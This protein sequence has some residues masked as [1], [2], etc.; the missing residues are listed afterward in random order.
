MRNAAAEGSDGRDAR[1]AGDR[2]DAG[3]LL[4]RR[5]VLTRG[6]AGAGALAF[7]GVLSACGAGSKGGT[8]P[9]GNTGPSVG[10]GKEVSLVTFAVEN[11][12]ASMDYAQCYDF[13]GML[14]VPSITE[15]LLR[16]DRAGRLAP[17][18]AT[19]Y[20][21]PDPHRVVFTIRPGVR[22]HDGTP[23]TA[24]D[25]AFSMSRH[26]DPNVASLLGF[27]YV[28]VDHV[29]VTGPLEVTAFMKQPDSQFIAVMSTNA[30]A[31]GSKAFIEKHGKQYGS[32]EIGGL[33]TGPY[34]FVSWVKGQS[35]TVERNPDYWNGKVV[36]RKVTRFTARVIQDEAT[37]LTALRAG[38]IDGQLAQLSGR[39][40]QSLSTA[41]N[42][43]QYRV[44][45]SGGSYLSFNLARKPWDDSRVRRALSLVV[46]RQGLLDSVWGG[47][48]SLI[49]SMVAPSNW[50]YAKSTFAAAYAQLPDYTH[51]GPVGANLADA[52]KLISQAGAHGTKGS[53]WVATQYDAQQAQSI[54]AAASQI[55][56][57]LSVNTVTQA[58]MSAGEAAKPHPYDLLISLSIPDVPDPGNFL[59]LLYAST[60]TSNVQ[61]YRNPQ[62]DAWLAEQNRI[63][64][65]PTKRAELLT[66]VQEV[67]VRDQVQAVLVGTDIVLSMNSRLGGYQLASPQFQWDCQLIGSISGS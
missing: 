59:G 1:N 10:G 41:T 65:D 45:S 43:R 38:E 9:V 12:A 15:P 3:I 51:T 67:I 37:L 18:V 54:Q 16:I 13:S 26:L 39:G 63:T 22:F 27:Y 33:G 7:T 58:A 50:S 31:V 48:G 44:P 19:E 29:A 57:D 46:P 36:P 5:E 32:P 53:I 4:R 35:Y 2:E 30:G 52:R 47:Q 20:R 34:R 23:L 14:V 6:V 25:V 66:K 11:D 17:N 55:G 62:V 8:G 28:N 40:V 49:K 42:V 24:E 56:L 61:S 60:S 64:S 21:V